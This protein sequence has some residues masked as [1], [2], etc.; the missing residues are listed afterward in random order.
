MAI[1]LPPANAVAK[2]I[3]DLIGRPVTAKTAPLA[4]IEPKARAVAAYVDEKNALQV[5]AF[6]DIAVGASLGAALVMIPPAVVDD[7]I[8]AKALDEMM[9]ENL[10]EVF[11]VLSAIFPKSGGPRLLLRALHA[12]ETPDDVTACLAKPGTRMDVEMSVGGYRSG[13]MGIVTV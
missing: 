2:L 3:G 5:V 12:T 8:K 11:N 9:A 4:N 1:P 6:C 13:R 10:Y 7:C